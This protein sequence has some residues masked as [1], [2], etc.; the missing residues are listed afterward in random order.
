MGAETPPD[1]GLGELE[2]VM[3]L[4]PLAPLRWLRG[5]QIPGPGRRHRLQLD[6]EVREGRGGGVPAW[7]V[8]IPEEVRVQPDPPT[9]RGPGAGRKRQF[10]AG[11]SSGTEKA[12]A[13]RSVPI[14]S[15]LCH[16]CHVASER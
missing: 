2:V 16:L 9:A 5:Q 14:W 10:H 7:D 11:I 15:E 6:W 1:F 3:D 8:L 4:R 13:S 12:E